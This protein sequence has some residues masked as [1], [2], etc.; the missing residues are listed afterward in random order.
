MAFEDNVL[1][2]P[3]FT[4]EECDS[5]KPYCYAVEKEL[6]DHGFGKHREHNS[7]GDVITTN[8]YFR[9]NF[10]ASHPEYA[11][12]FAD[13]LFQTNKD[14]EWPVAC[15]SWVN[16]YRKGQGIDWHN[17]QGS[18]GKSFSANIFIDGPTSPG[19]TYKPFRDKA[20]VR[21]NRKGFIHVF[22]CELFHTVPP[23][24]TDEDRITIGITVHSF[25]DINH[26]MIQ[27]LA[28]NSRLYQDTIILT[29]EHH[30]YGTGKDVQRNQNE[31]G[32]LQSHTP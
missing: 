23:I 20:L 16:I 29:K 13:F 7:L 26:T 5:I 28:F 32:S 2:L 24:T 14:L 4:E 18:M 22:P 1:E 27:Q 25:K 15:Q 21:E 8:N 19:I 3:F 12:R 31:E 11:D 30:E 17:H 6:L 9:Y 10:F